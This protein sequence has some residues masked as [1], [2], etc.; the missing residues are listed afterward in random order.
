MAADRSEIVGCEVKARSGQSHGP[1]HEGVD[2][3]KLARLHRLIHRWARLHGY[4]P[5]SVRVDV[6]GVLLTPEREPL[7]EHL[8]RV[9]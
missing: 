8:V 1:P 6:I 7:I 5:D 9:C 3:R 4:G 2:E